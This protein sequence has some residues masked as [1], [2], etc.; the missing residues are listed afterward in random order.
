MNLR[1]V[2]GG[3][4][5]RERERYENGRNEKVQKVEFMLL[6]TRGGPI[7]GARAFVC[8]VL[9]K[10]ACFSLCRGKRGKARILVFTLLVIFMILIPGNYF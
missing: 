3:G 8:F 4:G 1:C 9:V 10:L 6:V 2:E 7:R 5:G